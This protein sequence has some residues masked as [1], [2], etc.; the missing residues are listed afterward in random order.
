MPHYHP[1]LPVHRPL[2]IAHRAGNQPARAKRAIERGVDMLE[3]DVWRYR[4][5]LEVRHLKTLGP[6]PI[7]WDRWELRPGWTPRLHLAELLRETPPT[8]PIMLDLKGRDPNLAADI[9]ETMRQEHIEHEIVMC[10][11]NW[12]HLDR[13]HDA[14]DVHRIYS[15]GSQQERD[16]I[17]SR[18]ETMEHPAVSIHHDLVTPALMRRFDEAGVTVISWGATTRTEVDLLLSLGIDG[19]TVSEGPLQTWLLN[20]R[21]GTLGDVS[22]KATESAQQ[23]AEP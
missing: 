1:L 13:I 19:I 18:V 21:Q 6:L 8:I 12:L 22:P 14:G 7:L 4:K 10:T 9:L 16:A 2:V 3:A 5:N 15:V 23:G 11:R 17:F 20:E